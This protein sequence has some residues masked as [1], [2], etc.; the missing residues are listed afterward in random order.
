MTDKC[1]DN[2]F[3]IIAEA[4]KTLLRNTN[5]E[6]SPEEMAVIDRILY[7][8]WQIGLLDLW[9]KLRCRE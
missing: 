7:R 1:T 6:T 3:E 4:K 9:Y 2:R 5:I 8:C